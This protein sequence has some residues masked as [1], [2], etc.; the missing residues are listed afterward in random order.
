MAVS[1]MGTVN[2]NPAIGIV[3]LG[4]YTE[5]QSAPVLGRSMLVV[6]LKSIS[7][8]TSWAFKSKGMDPHK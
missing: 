2:A 3:P 4:E 5:T 8:K 1:I 6:V 7:G